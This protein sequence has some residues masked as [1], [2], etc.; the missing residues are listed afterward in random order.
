MESIMAEETEQP[1]N[2][3]SETQ[4]E[5]GGG[6]ESSADD[7]LLKAL[8]GDEEQPSDDVDQQAPEQPGEQAPEA[9]AQAKAEAEALADIE[10]NGKQYKLPAELKDAFMAQSDYTRKTQEVAEQR[11]LIDIQ[12]QTIQKQA[13][14]QKVIMPDITALGNL[15]LE[16]ARYDKLDWASLDT[17]TLIRAKHGRDTLIEQKQ[18]II[19]TI[20]EKGQKFEQE[21]AEQRR[22]AVEKGKEYLKRSVP[23]WSQSAEKEAISWATQK[24]YSDQFVQAS[25][26]PIQVEAWYKAAQWDK[27][28]SQKGAVTQKAN[29]APPIGKPGAS[30]AQN[31]KAQ[32]DRLYRTA[33]SQAKSS[34]DKAKIIDARIAEKFL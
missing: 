22:L 10:F 8:Y 17:D 19:G 20:R 3:G 9:E 18:K 25:V 4:L 32:K 7:R 16:I 34:A 33:L 31:T 5:D 24:G 27:L 21:M 1:V 28:Q 6:K 15:D 23:S 13:E 12:A 30:Q 2:T 14:L 26:D 11:K 29:A